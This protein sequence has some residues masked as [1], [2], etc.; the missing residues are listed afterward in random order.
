MCK[1][2]V[3]YYFDQ[4]MHPC[5]FCDLCMPEGEDDIDQMAED[6]G[7]GYGGRCRGYGCGG[8]GGYGGR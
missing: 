4:A 5:K 3:M 2:F 6:R 8:R 7:T 1:L